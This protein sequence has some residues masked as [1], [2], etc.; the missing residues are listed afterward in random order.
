MNYGSILK[1]CRE[2][3]GLSQ[4]ELAFQLFIN[5]SDVSKLEN[6][7]KEPSMSIFQK[8]S[9][10]TQSPDVL[11]AFIAGMDGLTILSNILSSMTGVVGFI[12]F[13]I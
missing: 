5:Q 12:K 11:V 8:W 3:K 1:A 10:A 7:S 6:G 2:R 13:L 9:T 4:A